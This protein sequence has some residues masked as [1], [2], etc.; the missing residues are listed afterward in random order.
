MTTP[1][2]RT[3]ATAAAPASAPE[4]RYARYRISLDSGTGAAQ[5]LAQWLPLATVWATNDTFP[6]T[7]RRVPAGLPRSA[8]P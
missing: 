5:T 7:T 8:R 6:G 3:P 2:A 1:P 4:D